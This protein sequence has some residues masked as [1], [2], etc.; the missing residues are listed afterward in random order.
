MRILLSSLLTLGIGLFV[1]AVAGS[2]GIDVVHAQ[3]PGITFTSPSGG[4]TVYNGQTKTITWDSSNV[5]NKFGYLYY[6]KGA[7]TTTFID[8][9]NLNISSYDWDVNN[10]PTGSDYYLW[11]YLDNPYPNHTYYTLSSAFTIANQTAPT[12]PPTVSLTSPSSGAIW[13]KGQT[14]RITWDSSNV[15]NKFG[16]LYY[17]TGSS[18]SL[19][20]VVNL[21][22]NYYDWPIPST[23]PSGSNY[24]INL[25]VDNPSPGHSAHSASSAFTI[26]TQPTTTPTVRI[27]SPNGGET[28]YKNQSATISWTSTNATNKFGYLYYQAGSTLVFIN[29]VNLNTNS[30]SWTPPTTLAS[31]SNYRILL[32]VDSAFPTAIW[33]ESDASFTLATLAALNPTVT[34]TSP[35]GGE[36]LVKGQARAI[37]WNSTNASSKTGYLYYYRGGTRVPIAPVSIGTGSYTW[38]PSTALPTASD[39]RIIMY[40]GSDYPNHETFGQSNADFTLAASG[41]ATPTPTPNAPTVTLTSPNGGETL[42]N[43]QAVNITWTSANASTKIGYIYYQKGAGP[44]IL[45]KTVN[46][47]AN[48]TDWTPNVPTGSDYRIHFYLGAPSPH[49]EDYDSSNSTF[50][51]A[52]VSA[53]TPTIALTA[54]VSGHR[55]TQDQALTISWTT[56]NAVGQSGSIYYQRGS[57]TRQQIASV[58]HNINNSFTWQVP[59]GLANGSDYR[60]IIEVGAGSSIVGTATSGLFTV[61]STTTQPPVI[62]NPNQLAEG[63][64]IIEPGTNNVYVIRDGKK[65]LVPSVDAFQKAGYQWSQVQQVAQEVVN[66]LEEARVIRAQNGER[67]YKIVGSAIVWIPTEQA[68]TEQF[69]WQ[70]IAIVQPTEIDGYHFARLVR[71]EGDAKVY[72]INER[73]LKHH[74]VS[75]DVFLS[76]GNRWEDIVVIS[77]QDLNMYQ[78][79]TLVRVDGDPKVYL[80]ENGALRWITTADAFNR[81]G[82]N[83]SHIVTIAPF[84]RAAYPQGADIL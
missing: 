75:A 50:T 43:G 53:N 5:A 25:Y 27:L 23:L 64:L 39:Y 6:Q 40:V 65:V 30:Y 52:T 8:A 33:D 38:T 69:S 77:P 63:S 34:I 22:V 66:Q 9:V 19:I 17:D 46:A 4:S 13:Y 7:G 20:S 58:V 11:M 80:L 73:G 48:T 60:I 67:V 2:L 79:S 35:N 61:G 44:L 32:S 55:V 12:N 82:L 1:F 3:T 57:A 18:A 59:S 10:L 47:G 83:W 29:V 15:A 28:L 24:R 41:T 74:I 45:I 56:Q 37:T 84:E 81:R 21:N 51:I 14:K 78:T 72:Y 70:D 31:G 68:L 49:H 36:T 26:T 62:T 16:Y 54:P 42:Y 71:A 76:Y